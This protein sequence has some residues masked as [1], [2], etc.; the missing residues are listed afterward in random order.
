MPR[1][2]HNGVIAEN[3]RAR[4]DYD[5]LET[6]EAGLVLTGAE[7]KSVRDG[8]INI[9]QAYVNERRGELWLVNA[10]VAE[11]HGAGGFTQHDPLR[12]KKLLVHRKQIAHLAGL[13]AQQRLTIVPLRVYIKNHVAKVLIGVAR[14][15]RQYDKREAIKR[16]ETDREI[17]RAQKIRSR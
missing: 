16:R 2:S 5:I 7:I 4:H 15:R 11:Y 6:V 12:P 13:A 10:H 8:K 1:A 14:G 17:R 9:S 3:R